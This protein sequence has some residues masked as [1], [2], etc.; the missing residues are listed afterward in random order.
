MLYCPLARTLIEYRVH[1]ISAVRVEDGE[2]VDR[3]LWVLLEELQERKQ[4][5]AAE[6]TAL[7]ARTPTGSWKCAPA[8]TSPHIFLQWT[9]LTLPVWCVLSLIGVR[10]AILT[11]NIS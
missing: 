2:E 9:P 4:A 11:H 10:R 7:R 5:L 8:V 6:N 1:V 3:E